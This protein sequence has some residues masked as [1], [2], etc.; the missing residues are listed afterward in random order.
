M[1]CLFLA[2]Q[3]K[4]LLSSETFQDESHLE[5]LPGVLEICSHLLI[6]KWNFFTVTAQT[7]AHPLAKKTRQLRDAQTAAQLE[8]IL[9]LIHLSIKSGQPSIVRDALSLLQK[10]HKAHKLLDILP[11]NWIALFCDLILDTLASTRR[12][13]LLDEL[14]HTLYALTASRFQPFV[15]YFLPNKLASHD[16]SS[17]STEH[18]MTGFQNLLLIVSPGPGQKDQPNSCPDQEAFLS[19]L[20]DF[21]DNLYRLNRR[22][23]KHKEQLPYY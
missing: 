15:S 6:D 5:V 4:P 12:H 19:I 22:L 23:A 9:E 2:E 16:L 7:A 1:I 3:L 10:S 21:L 18:L 14:S 11:D 17:S 13:I 8:I 20:F